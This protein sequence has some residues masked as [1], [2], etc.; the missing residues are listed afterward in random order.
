MSKASKIIN[1][2]IF[3]FAIVVVVFGVLLFQKREQ[4]TQ[5]R[6][7]IA[8]TVE[9]VSRLIDPSATIPA[10]DLKISK[11]P[12]EVKEAMVKLDSAVDK[13]VKQRNAIAENL[14]EVTNTV[15]EKAFYGEGD[16]PYILESGSVTNYKTTD[17]T[18]AEIKTHI[19]E[20]M[21][22]FYV[23]DKHLSEFMSKDGANLGM[24]ARNYAFSADNAKLSNALN[25]LLAK[26]N[27]TV[28]RMKAFRGHIVTVSNQISPDARELDLNSQEY[29]RLLRENVTT[30]EEF[31][32]EHK[33]LVKDNEELRIRV[34]RAEVA[35][36]TADENTANYKKVAEEVSQKLTEAEKEIRRLRVIIDPT[37]SGEGDDALNVNFTVLKD[38]V[39]K[40]VYVNEQYGYITVDIGSE[41]TVIR[42][43]GERLR[44]AVPE[45][46][47]LTVA[48]SLDPE[49]AKYVC[50]AQVIRLRGNASVATILAS[51]A[52]TFNYPSVGDVVYFS[53][54][55]LAT[56]KAAHDEAMRKKAEER[57]A[58]EQAQ[59]MQDFNDIMTGEDESDDSGIDSGDDF[60]DGLDDAEDDAPADDSEDDFGLDEE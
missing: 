24:P 59:S 28:E 20:R 35:L 21:E 40:V 43:N 42:S 1:I 9:K 18:L 57:A 4:I 46:A 58:L 39:G 51:P 16:E 12:A 6:S 34:E 27:D 13:I 26:T 33:R 14:T 45:G 52:G 29:S 11:T 41:S 10:D 25:E 38:L 23:R 8:A 17:A 31:V 37:G 55:D 56:M 7:D 54:G 19:G 47:L 48:T 53:Q 15:L 49:T 60:L 2:F 32:N 5:A 3:V 22:Y 30:V 44:A 50:K 36:G